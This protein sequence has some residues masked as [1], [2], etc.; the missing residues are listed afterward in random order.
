MNMHPIEVSLMKPKNNQMMNNIF[1]IVSSLT[2]HVMLAAGHPQ[3]GA[4]CIPAQEVSVLLDKEHREIPTAVSIQ[5]APTYNSMGYVF[6]LISPL[7]YQFITNEALNNRALLEI[8]AGFSNI[9]LES[10]KK[11]NVTYIANDLSF[12]HLKVLVARLK[13]ESPD[14]SALLMERLFLLPG[15]APNELPDFENMFDA[16][17]MDKVFHFFA[18]QDIEFFMSWAKKVLKPHGKIYILTLSPHIKFFNSRLLADYKDKRSCESL[19]PGYITNVYDY[20]DQE[21]LKIN[22]HYQIPPLTT[23]FT[24]PDL[25]KLFSLNSFKILDSYCVALPKPD[26][27]SW[28]IVEDEKGDL[29]ALIAQKS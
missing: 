19:Y 14:Q 9:A 6:Y 28:K 12:D 2:G 26:H 11:G 17:L 4:P 23:F 20:M 13:Q 5:R 16:I 25:E 15:R 1:F 8:G 10:I 24:R 7:G 27:E 29:I 21:A 3:L 18:P 22:P